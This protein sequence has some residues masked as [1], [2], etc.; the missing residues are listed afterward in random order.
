MK[1]PLHED[2]DG[3]YFGDTGPLDNDYYDEPKHYVPE[4]AYPNWKLV[5]RCE[6]CGRLH[7]LVD[8]DAVCKGCGASL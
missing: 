1:L 7:W 4:V 3:P 5:A 6:Y 2:T 8:K